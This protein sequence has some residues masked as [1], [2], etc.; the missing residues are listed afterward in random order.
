[1]T[2]A[3]DTMRI[4]RLIEDPGETFQPCQFLPLHTEPS[5]RVPPRIFPEA[6]PETLSSQLHCQAISNSSGFP[7][8]DTTVRLA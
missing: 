7:D 3:A 5:P 2:Q 8:S 1:M 4:A 6:N